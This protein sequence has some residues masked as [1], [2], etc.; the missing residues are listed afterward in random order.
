[1]KTHEPQLRP[2]PVAPHTWATVRAP[3]SM[4]RVTASSLTTSQ[5][6]TITAYSDVRDPGTAGS[7]LIRQA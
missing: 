4:A 3:L 2:A 5:W 6:Q 7:W 1:M